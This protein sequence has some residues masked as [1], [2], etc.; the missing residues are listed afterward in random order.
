MES[1]WHFCGGFGLGT[2]W[3]GWRG[4]WAFWAPAGLR[5]EPRKGEGAEGRRPGRQCS[6][7]GALEA[8]EETQG[9]LLQCPS[10]LPAA[11]GPSPP[12][13]LIS[14]FLWGLLRARSCLD[15]AAEAEEALLPASPGRVCGHVS[16]GGLGGSLKRCHRTQ[17]KEKRGYR[18]CTGLSSDP[19]PTASSFCDSGHCRSHLQP[20]FPHLSV[21][22]RLIGLLHRLEVISDVLHWPHCLSAGRT[23]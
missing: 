15:Q 22:L 2:G 23:G 14:C 1:G 12:V 16:V 3:E 9:G 7:K 19:G 17:G 21:G 18:H 13:P 6:D 20:Q 5:Q 8:P 4:G 11:A 10:S